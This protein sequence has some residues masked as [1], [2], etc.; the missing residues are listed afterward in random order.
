MVSRNDRF[1]FDER[2]AEEAAARPGPQ[3]YLPDDLSQPRS[4]GVLG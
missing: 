2:R 1:A 3:T 4:Q